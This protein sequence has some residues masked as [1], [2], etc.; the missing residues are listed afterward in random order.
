MEQFNTKFSKIVINVFHN[1]EFT[2]ETMVQSFSGNF[3]IF[4]SR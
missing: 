2:R 4:V 1:P 3:I